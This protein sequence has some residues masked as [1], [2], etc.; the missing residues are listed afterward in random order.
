MTWTPVALHIY[1]YICTTVTQPIMKIV[2]AQT[3]GIKKKYPNKSENL[4][5]SQIRN[6]DESSEPVASLNT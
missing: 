2:N 4:D 5:M 3:Q 6:G 1:I